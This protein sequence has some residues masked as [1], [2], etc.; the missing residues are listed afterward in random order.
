M[1]RQRGEMK[2][3]GEGKRVGCMLHVSGVDGHHRVAGF[4]NRCEGG[5]DVK[6]GHRGER[7]RGRPPFRP[8]LKV[9][10]R[11]AAAS[12]LSTCRL[13]SLAA[14]LLRQFAPIIPLCTSP[15]TATLQAFSKV[16]GSK[17]AGL[18]L[19]PLIAWTSYATALNYTLLAMNPENT[20][21]A[22]PSGTSGSGSDAKEQVAKTVKEAKST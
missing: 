2:G 8:L 1:R 3:E 9:T 21:K 10:G 7:V 19:G 11:Q 4:G 20:D 22:A 6:R 13:C 16:I 15:I 14:M 17:A 18:T 12:N 5:L